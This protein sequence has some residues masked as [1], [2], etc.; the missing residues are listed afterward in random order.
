MEAKFWFKGDPQIIV[1]L[2]IVTLAQWTRTAVLVQPQSK[3]IKMVKNG[4]F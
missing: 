4:N 2:I 3:N 1:T